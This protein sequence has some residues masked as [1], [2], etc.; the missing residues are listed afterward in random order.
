MVQHKLNG[1]RNADAN[2][3]PEMS[4][5]VFYFFETIFFDDTIVCFVL[6]AKTHVTATPKIPPVTIALH[7]LHSGERLIAKFHPEG[8]CYI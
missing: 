2:K 4:K 8:N 3:D 1:D 7:L 6:Q 5:E